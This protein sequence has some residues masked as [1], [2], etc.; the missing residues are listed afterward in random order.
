VNLGSNPEE[1]NLVGD[2]AHGYIQETNPALRGL[3][4]VLWK[5]CEDRGRRLVFQ[6]PGPLCECS[7]LAK[8]GLA[9]GRL[10]SIL[11][12]LLSIRGSSLTGSGCVAQAALKS[13]SLLSAGVTGVATVPSHLALFGLSQQVIRR[14]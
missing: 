14:P 11:F 1:E 2:L 5:S 7:D 10:P 4:E 9:P 3:Q 8:D 6:I 12:I 13:L